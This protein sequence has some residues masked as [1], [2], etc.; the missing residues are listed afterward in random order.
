[1]YRA[2]MKWGEIKKAELFFVKNLNQT[3]DL[4]DL[5]ICRKIILKCIL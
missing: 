5:G 2:C 1:M 4:G 3:N